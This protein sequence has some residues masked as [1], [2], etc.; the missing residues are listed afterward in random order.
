M[1]LFNACALQHS[2]FVNIFDIAELKEIKANGD[3]VSIGS[4]ATYTQI[5][6]HPTLSKDF[7]LLCEAARL[8]GAV[9]IQN[10]GTLG[11]NIANASP[12]ADSPPALL[13]YDAQI[14]LVSVRGSR[15]VPYSSFHTGYKTTIMAPDEMISAIVLPRR[16][17]ECTGYYRKVGPR[18]AQAIS[19]IC[20]AG[21]CR[22]EGGIIK[23]IRVALGSVAPTPIRCHRTETELIGKTITAD[24][25]RAAMSSLGKEIS[26]IDD[27]RS[28]A[29]Y[30]RRVAQNLLRDFLLLCGTGSTN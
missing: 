21:N 29:S 10:R 4:C 9:A 6:S 2:R 7:P 20:L 19:K 26:P 17:A 12:A 15:V 3:N 18:A 16:W 25:I 23:D 13:A 27:L 28:T 22:A 5:R 1:V 14:E 24:S 30:R 8:T 11:G